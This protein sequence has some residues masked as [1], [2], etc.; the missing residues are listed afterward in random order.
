MNKKLLVVFCCF[1]LFAVTSAGK[2]YCNCKMCFKPDAKGTAADDLSN[3]C[4]QSMSKGKCAKDATTPAQCKDAATVVCNCDNCDEALK[5]TCAADV[6]T[7]KC[8]SGTL[9]GDEVM[10]ADAVDITDKCTPKPA[11][12]G[13]GTKTSFCSDPTTGNLTHIATACED[14]DLTGL[15]SQI[16]QTTSDQDRD[17][18]CLT[19]PSFKK[20]CPK[21]CGLCCTFPRYSCK[22]SL[23]DDKCEAYLDYCQSSM[24]RQILASSCPATCG[25]CSSSGGSGGSGCGD[26]LDYCDK[27]QPYCNTPGFEVYRRQ[28]A[29]TCGTC[30]ERKKATGNGRIPGSGNRGS[31]GVCRDTVKN[32]ISLFN[33]CHHPQYTYFTKV[34]CKK[35][36]RFC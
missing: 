13:N 21:T 28:C 35:T 2:T 34:Y 23:G 1:V 36:C 14:S 10:P 29:A 16:N 22:N 32:C 5:A 4:V 31:N 3:D 11:S 9:N 8:M 20:Y 7:G 19:D 15:C 33:K 17:E 24:Y 6:I 26:K 30:G 18:K 27:M 12:A 25:F